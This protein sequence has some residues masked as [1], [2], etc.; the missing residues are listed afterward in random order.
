MTPYEKYR[1][2]CLELVNELAPRLSAEEVALAVELIEHNECPEGIRLLAFSVVRHCLRIPASTIARMR[3]AMDG[4]IDPAHLPP[5]LE[6]CA[7]DD[8]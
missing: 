1:V 5:D 8:E 3:E 4:F 2:A 6:A 7:T